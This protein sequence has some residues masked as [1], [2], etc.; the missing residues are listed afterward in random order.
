[1]ILETNADSVIEELPKK[2]ALLV[3]TRSDKGFD[4]VL[5]V[6]ALVPGIQ[7]VAIASQS[8]R[9]AA[10]AAVQKANVE[11]VIIIDRTSAME[12]LYRA[13]HVVLVPSFKFV[14]TFSRV[15]IEAHRV[16]TP[17]LG[18]NRGN[19]PR[20]L[21][22]SGIV[23]TEDPTRWANA[24]TALY[25]DVGLYQDAVVR[26]LENS[27]RYSQAAQ[28]SAFDRVFAAVSRPLLVGIGSGIG[29]MLHVGPTIRNIARRT[30]RP[31]DVVVPE[32]HNASLFLLHD[33]RYVNEV[34]TLH[35]PILN[36][37]YETVF[38]THC[39]GG[40]RVPFS[41]DRLL[42]SRDWDVF[43]PGESVHETIFNLEA[44][45]ALLG[46]DYDPED[47]EAH[48]IGELRY[49]WSDGPVVGVHGGSKPGYWAS[50]RWPYFPDLCAAL[51]ARGF[52]VVSFGQPDEY[53]EGAEDQT[54]GT[55]AEMAEA[56]R[57]CSWFVSSDTG[58]MNVANAL[59][60]PCLSVFGPTEV[61]TR[62][63][64]GARNATVAVEK[65][66]APC[67]VKD[68][69]LFKTGGCRCIAEIGV[70][71]VLA[72]F[73]TLQARLRADAEGGAT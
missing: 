18:S 16:G 6:A 4:L 15:C 65:D 10:M 40:V 43:R 61:A 35:A 68:P 30:G 13:A 66:C 29:N 64:L 69:A 37:H 56:M 2:F 70:D 20:L 17:V 26:A 47:V 39:F 41:C 63:P 58:V 27:D 3:N 24:L 9:A 49:A 52:R 28:A 45:K 42:S 48:Y 12:P 54:G 36:R 44:A 73:E 62:A 67:E 23:L 55:I 60:I 31:V 59:G 57:M 32:D 7:F 22:E 1:M 14:E 8:G 50:K 51:K 11:N 46:I 38:L 72:E 5:E 25:E 19:V 33:P 53:V 71:R 21:E 34:H